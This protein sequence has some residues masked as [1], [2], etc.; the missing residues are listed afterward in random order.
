MLPK[1]PSG[2]LTPTS[3]PHLSGLTTAPGKG[4]DLGTC[5]PKASETLPRSQI[6]NFHT[7]SQN[8]TSPK[9][10]TFFDELSSPPPFL[11]CSLYSRIIIIIAIIIIIIITCRGRN[12]LEVF[13]EVYLIN[14]PVIYYPLV[15]IQQNIII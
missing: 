9:W 6:S 13:L 7:I 5:S 11:M 4:R 1:A 8:K 12:W 10:F 2:P 15:G 14:I 3:C